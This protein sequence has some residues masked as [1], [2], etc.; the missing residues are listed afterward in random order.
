MEI[1]EAVL[2]GAEPTVE[3][4]EHLE[5]CTS[6]ARD[7]DEL[8]SVLK[9]LDEWQAPEPSPYFDTR[10]RARL[11]A[12]SNTPKPLWKLVQGEA[13]GWRLALA[14]VVVGFLIG[15]GL[16]FGN[17]RRVST[18]VHEACAVVDLQSLDRNA[19]LL[20]ELSWLEDGEPGSD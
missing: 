5:A 19:D 16:F 13:L 9:L 18:S 3:K 12:Q 20:S 2:F 7:A 8:A 4:S 17:P 11:R 15:Y 1:L 6:C 10:L 14:I